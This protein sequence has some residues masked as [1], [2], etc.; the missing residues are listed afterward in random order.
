M[1]M[2]VLYV[3][4]ENYHTNYF[5]KNKTKQKTKQKQKQSELDFSCAYE[6]VVYKVEKSNVLLLLK[7]YWNLEIK[8]S[9]KFFLF[10]LTIHI[11]FTSLQAGIMIWSHALTA[12][13]R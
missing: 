10:F 2:S 12:I 6:M 3:K 8:V 7:T 13:R 1:V 5:F 9:S 4:M 11:W